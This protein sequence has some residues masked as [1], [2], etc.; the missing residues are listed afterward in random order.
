VPGH[1]LLEGTVQHPPWTI[2]DVI[3]ENTAS[4]AGSWTDLGLCSPPDRVHFSAGVHAWFGRFRRIART[5]RAR[6][7]FPS[8]ER[9]MLATKSAGV[10]DLTPLQ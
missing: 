7:F 9:N 8:P 5:P 6:G 2:R 4:E 10:T 3:L 1:G